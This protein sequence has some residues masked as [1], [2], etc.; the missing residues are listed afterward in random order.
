[1]PKKKI[2][3]LFFSQLLI[4]YQG[5][6]SKKCDPLGP[7][8]VLRK[9]IVMG[10]MVACDVAQGPFMVVFPFLPPKLQVQPILS[11]KAM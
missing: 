1:M 3:M 2:Q 8:V 9:T 7:M 11:V 6:K 10:I 5:E 4:T